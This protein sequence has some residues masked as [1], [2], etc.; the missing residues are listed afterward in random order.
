[1]G[2]LEKEIQQ[3]TGIGGIISKLKQNFEILIDRYKATTKICSNLGLQ[4][5]KTTTIK[6]F[7]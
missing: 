6:N 2:Y 7:F 1:M 5:L 3:N 4:K